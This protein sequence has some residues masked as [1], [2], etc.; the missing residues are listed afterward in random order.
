[1]PKWLDLPP[2]WLIAM[3]ALVYVD[4]TMIAPWPNLP[5][6]WIGGA[7]MAVGV[8]LAIW[9][10]LSFR[11]AKTTIVP[12][13]A[14][15][16]LITTGAFAYSRNPIYLADAIVLVGWTLIFGAALPFVIVILFILIINARFIRPEE[17]RLSEAF[18]DE[19]TVYAS[20]VRRWI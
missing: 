19:F 5:M 17:Q 4:A 18:G 6:P 11:A 12:H 10:A 2:L 16:A 15:S 20:T 9:A 13:Q 3:M 7:V 14:P 8:G 1:M